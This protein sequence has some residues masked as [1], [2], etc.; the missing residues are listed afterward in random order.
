MPHKGF[1]FDL[2][3]VVVD[4]ATY[5]YLSWKKLA[6][7]LGFDINEA[8]NEQLKGVSRDQSLRILLKWGNV[9]VTEPEFTR[10]MV[11]KNNDYLSYISRM[12][13]KEI[14]PGVL[15]VLNYMEQKKYPI[16][17]G[18]ASKNAK[19]ILEKTAINQFFDVIIDGNDVT[20][21]KPDPEVFVTAAR[22]MNL[23][24]YH[25]VVFE[26]SAAGIEAA[27]TAGMISVGI[28]SKTILRQADYIFKAFTEMPIGFIDKLIYHESGLYHTR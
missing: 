8:Q 26:D 22:R 19:I 10:L 1:I 28:G 6:N 24:P 14:L 5:H 13:S 25:C 21:A 20:A 9:S 27:R 12:S 7:K 17:L 11:E 16:A 18:S 3:G 23:A 15:Q 4:T 2:D